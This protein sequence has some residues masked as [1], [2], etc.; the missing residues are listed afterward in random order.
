MLVDMIG[1]GK[2]DMLA[3]FLKTRM[4]MELS[5]IASPMS[6]E[7]LRRHTEINEIQ[8]VANR[9]YVSHLLQPLLEG[10][11]VSSDD[12]VNGRV[13]SLVETRNR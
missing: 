10:I 7:E 3:L 11:Q 9:I 2:M 5:A 6:V 12:V 8:S 1:G 13:A 4:L